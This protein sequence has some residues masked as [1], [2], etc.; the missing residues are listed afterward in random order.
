LGPG[1]HAETDDRDSAQ[2][3]DHGSCSHGV[4]P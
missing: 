1:G 4:P 2:Q 3:G